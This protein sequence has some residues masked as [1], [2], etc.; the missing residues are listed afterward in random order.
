MPETNSWDRYL[1]PR[2]RNQVD[3]ITSAFQ[4]AEPTVEIGVIP[5]DN[6]VS[7]MYAEGQLLVR[8]EYLGRVQEILEQPVSDFERIER[9]V[10][11]VTLLTLGRMPSGEQ[12]TVFEALIR[13]DRELGVGIATPNHVLTVAGEVGPCPATE[14]EEVDYGTEPFPSV[15]TEN[16]GAGVLIYVADTGLLADAA[17]HPWLAGVV[18]DDPNDLDP[19]P[20]TQPDGTLKILPYTGHGTFVAGVARCMAP[21]ANV[22]VSNIFAVAGSALESDFVQ[23]LDRALDLGV[24]IFNLS[25]TTATRT[26]LPL[27]GFDGFLRRL[28][29]YKGV[30][31][32]VA[33]GNNGLRNPSWPAAYPEMVSVGALGGDWRDR[34]QF[35]NYGAWVDVYAPGRDLV[36]AFATGTYTCDDEPYKGEIRKFY[37]MARWMRQV[38]P[39][40]GAAALLPLRQRL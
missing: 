8:D 9:I 14:P 34:A 6:G 16:G 31:C 18:P 7:Y 17:S 24:D 11:G 28:R 32:V 39:P 2:I 4:A 5:A 23:Q 40:P 27:L 36:N 10:S 38:C 26:D 29:Q 12:L 22:I 13:I 35:S 33:A 30:V 21:E 15:C 37:G 3:R 25:I 20:V 19:A 1:A